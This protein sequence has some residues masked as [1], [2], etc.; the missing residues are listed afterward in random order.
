MVLCHLETKLSSFSTMATIPSHNLLTKNYHS[1]SPF[2]TTS[3]SEPSF[4]HLPEKR[5]RVAA[6]AS[7]SR[8]NEAS[9]SAVISRLE[10]ERQGLTDG[11]GE[12]WRTAEDFR[13]R[14][15]KTEEE[16]RLRDTWRKIQGE[17]DWAGLTDPM[18]PVLRSELIRY[19]EMAQACYDAFDFDPSSR[20]CGS[21]RFSRHEFFDSLG[22]KG[23]GYEVAR[24]LYATSNINLPNFF[25]KSRWSKVWSKNANWMGY[26]AVSDDEAT[27]HRLGRRD[28]AIAWRGT[29]TQLEW[30]ADLKD[31]LKP[32]S[33]NNLRCPDPAV[34]VESGF[35]DLYTDKDT[36]CKFSRFSAREQVL[37]E[38]KRLVE[39]Y[40]DDEDEELSITVTGH[41]LGGALAILSAYDVAEMGLNRSRSGKVIP[42]TVLTYGGPRVGNVRFKERLKELGVK[43]MRVVNVHDVVPK[44]PGLFLNERAPHAVMKIAEGLPWC[45]CHV[46]EELALDHQNSPFLKS[47]VDPSNAHN[48]EA[49]LH[50]LDGYHGKGERFVLSN[51]RDPALVNKA[52]DFLKEHFMVPPFWRQDANKGMVRNSEG[53]WIQAERLRSEDHHSPDIH[54]HLSQLR[55]LPS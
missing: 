24:Y 5:S 38:V 42:V 12:Q 21:S 32:V 19:G 47:S 1:S 35:L 30:I 45:Y 7:L 13:R 28:I 6:K 10:R 34:K 43:V 55:L 15:K 50:L 48:L 29:V 25:S 31:Y 22:M 8:T 2:K 9:L 40:G 3:S 52:S 39:R 54:H 33:G 11:G 36:S 20:Y 44:S 23:S 18:D 41:S 49:L 27:R 26:V 14:D 17:D 51:G 46:G 4:I 37:A 53:R 16:R